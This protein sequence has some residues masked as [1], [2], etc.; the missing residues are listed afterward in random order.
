MYPVSKA[1]AEANERFLAPEGFVELSC[2]IPELDETLV[3]TK[4]DLM[5]FTHQQTGC[6]V[7]GELPKNYIEFSLDNSSGKWNPNSPRG[8]ERYLSERL[9]ITLRYGFDTH[10]DGRV[11]W[12]PGGVFYLSEWHTS[13]DGLEASFVARDLLEYM[14]DVPYTGAITGTLYDIASNAIAEAGIPDDAVVDLDPILMDYVVI[15][16]DYDGVKSVAEVLQRCANAGGCVM[17][18][19]R[20][21]VLHVRK[22]WRENPEYTI[23]LSLSYSYP[24]I[25]LLKPLRSVSVTYGDNEVYDHPYQDTGEIQTVDNEFIQTKNQAQDVAAWVADALKLR[26]KISG[27]F[28]GDLCIDLFD[29]VRIENKY[30]TVSGATIT[31]IKYTFTG[32]FRAEYVGYVRGALMTDYI[33]CGDVFTGEVN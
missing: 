11:E 33:Y 18:Q 20:E 4:S 15:I 26:K 8:L 30:G 17:Y 2:Y 27:S 3:Y 6:L 14:I 23:P 28:R 5:G 12:I 1:W 9:R 22:S 16:E 29:T 31:D 25:E 24:K 32:A 13:F 19:D 10:G 7:A 21:G